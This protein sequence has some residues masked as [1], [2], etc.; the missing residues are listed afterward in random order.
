MS[1]HHGTSAGKLTPVLT[2]CV[3]VHEIMCA[4]SVF[5]FLCSDDV[6]NQYHTI[7]QT[8]KDVYVKLLALGLRALVYN[9]DTDMACNFLGD[10]WFVEQLGQKVSSLR[11]LSCSAE[12]KAPSW[13]NS[14]V[15]FK[16]STRYQHWIYDNQIAGFYQQFGNITFLT[17]KVSLCC[18]FPNC[19]NT[20][21][22]ASIRSIDGQPLFEIFIEIHM[23]GSN[24][25]DIQAKQ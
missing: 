2:V 10:Q 20:L 11:S 24:Q 18:S 21:L 8:V 12:F 14:L 5:P 7:Y 15:F 17:V 16:A 1:F 19:S 3:C 22:P 4:Y 13:F 25:L 6:G 23:T 9:G